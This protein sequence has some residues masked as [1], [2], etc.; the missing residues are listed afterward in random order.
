MLWFFFLGPLLSLPFLALAFVLPYGT[1]LRDAPAKVRLLLL[2]CGV[3]FGGMLLP[4]YVSPHYAAPMTA[5]IYGLI[6]LTMQR[7]R[8]W[9][10][11]PFVCR[12]IILGAL[13]L[14]LVR[15]GA[16]I[17]HLP[18]INPAKPETWCSPWD[19]LLVR[20]TLERGL[21]ALAGR[22]VV[23]V[24]YGKHPNSG[25]DDSVWV[26]NSADIDSSK[27]VWAHDMGQQNEEL[28]RH[29]AGRK[30]WLLEV[31]KDPASFSAYETGKNV[32]NAH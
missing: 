18:L 9:K 23:L 22:H 24:H 8:R 2:V 6:M 5:A 26:N 31:D 28:I 27:V 21:E 14:L 32:S 19:Q 30:F 15:V 20:Q 7:L 4:V 10:A 12:A 16:P 17:F 29:F 1:S 25:T 11:G 13:G 3:T